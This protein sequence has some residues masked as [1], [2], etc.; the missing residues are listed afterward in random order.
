MKIQWGTKTYS[1]H[2]GST[3]QYPEITSSDGLIAFTNINTLNAF[4]SETPNGSAVNHC[5]EWDKGRSTV[6][7]IVACTTHG[8]GDLHWFIIGY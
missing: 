8:S 5:A 1:A 4:F 3:I 6:S 2:S 7:K